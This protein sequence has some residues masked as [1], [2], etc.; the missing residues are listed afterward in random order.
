MKETAAIRYREET[1][2]L[3]AEWKHTVG[4]LEYQKKR[5]AETLYI[6]HRNSVFIKDGIVCPDIW[7][8]QE[9]RPLFLLKEAH[10]GNEDWDLIEDHLRQGYATSKMWRRVSEWTKGLMSTAKDHIPPYVSG[11]PSVLHFD[12]EY[13]KQIAV[14]NVKKSRGEKDSDM[15]V[16]QAYAEFDKKHLLK[17]IEL[18][19]PSMIVCGYTMSALETI[20]GKPIRENYNHNHFYHVSLNGHDML[21]LDYWHP[22][23][24]YPDLMNYYGLMNIYRLA[25]TDGNG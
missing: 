7:F 22:A 3:F 23:N 17:Q 24:Q 6:D 4:M 18:C 15:D 11:D 14:V 20:L 13:L 19:D 2:K 10:G 8:S 21:V 16:I 9:V 1:E 5:E 25:L 12:N